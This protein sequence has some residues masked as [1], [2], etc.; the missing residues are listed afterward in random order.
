MQSNVLIFL[1]SMHKVYWILNLNIISLGFRLVNCAMCASSTYNKEA[2]DKNILS[3]CGFDEKV[4]K[5]IEAFARSY[6]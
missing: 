3:I 4:P 1:L 2:Y 5:I 6:F